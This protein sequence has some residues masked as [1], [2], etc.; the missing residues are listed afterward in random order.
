M[1]PV[2]A[3]LPLV[4]Y[5]AALV[6]GVIGIAVPGGDASLSPLAQWMLLLSLGLHSLWAAFGHLMAADMVAK[7]IGWPT[8]PFQQEVGAAN[9]GIGLA[10]VAATFLGEGAGWVVLSWP[11]RSCGVRHSFTSAA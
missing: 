1:S 10:A 2:I 7:S 5:A 3:F 11:L 9:L 4:L 8:S 6:L